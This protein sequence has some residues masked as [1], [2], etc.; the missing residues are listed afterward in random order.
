MEELPERGANAV[1]VKGDIADL[2]GH[3]T[4]VDRAFNAFGGFECLVN[5]AGISVRKRGDILD[6][7]RQSYDEV[8]NVNL[9]GPFFL[10]QEV[11]RRMI[12]APASAHPR[13]I[14]SLS[15]MNALR[16]LHRIGQNIACPRPASR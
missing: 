14:I 13:S 1:F 2:N 15:S 7:T 10:T 3:P 6:V 11:A 16:G 12:A 4:L 9:R 8:M 5:N